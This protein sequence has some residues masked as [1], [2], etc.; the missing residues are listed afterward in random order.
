VPPI[1]ADRAAGGDEEARVSAK[2]EDWPAERIKAAI[3]EKGLSQAAL[4]RQA[5]LSEGAVRQAMHTPIPAAERAV[6]ELLGVPVQQIWP[7]RYFPDGRRRAEPR[8]PRDI[9]ANPYGPHRQNRR[10]P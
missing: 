6:A 8:I 2:H 9:T 1:L 10:A 5:G 4:A 7:S 3:Y